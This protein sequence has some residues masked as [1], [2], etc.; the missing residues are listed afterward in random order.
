MGLYGF[1]IPEE[2]GGLGL[3]M[4][5]EVQLVFELGYTSPALRSMFGTNNGI[6]GHVLLEGG[7]EEQ[8]K[9][10]LPK[11][12]SGELTASF[13]LTETE[14]GSDPSTLTT[15]A[16]RDGDDLGPQR[17]QALHHQRA[18]R[19]RLH[20]VRP[21]QSGG[22]GDAWH[23]D[24]PRAPGPTRA[25]GRAQGQEDGP[26]SAPGR[27]RSTSTTC[28]WMAR[29]WSAARTAST[30]AT[31]RRCDASPMAG[32]TWRPAASAWP[33]ASS[34]SPSPTRRAATSRDG[35]SPASS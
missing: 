11:L 24:V 23:L 32:P 5:E 14:A 30:T 20:G 4:E 34:T 31:P 1:A 13:A 8:K 35:P 18:D 27:R 7:T 10:W 9:E 29:P 19:G 17:L 6:A 16:E 21:H 2:Y 28:G 12:A 15:S 33:A 22:Q 3:N 26:G 25:D